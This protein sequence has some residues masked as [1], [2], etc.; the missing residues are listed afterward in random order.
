M[1]TMIEEQAVDVLINLIDF[2]HEKLFKSEKQVCNGIQA[3][4][5]RLL[6]LLTTVPMI[7]MTALGNMLYISKPHMTT[8]VDTLVAE[9]LVERHPDLQDRRVINISITEKGCERLKTLR[10]EVRMKMKTIISS[11]PESDLEEL[12]SCGR[13][14]VEIVSKID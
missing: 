4:Q 1:E 9:E 11:L 2:Y 14:L 5:F 7:S 6:Y 8:L 13:H 12:C 3:A 10:T